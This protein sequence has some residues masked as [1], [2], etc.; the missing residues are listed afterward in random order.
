MLPTDYEEQ[1][2]E[3]M[4]HDSRKLAPPYVVHGSQTFHG[5]RDE[6]CPWEPVFENWHKGYIITN[7]DS[8]EEGRV[9]EINHQCVS[10]PVSPLSSPKPKQIESRKRRSPEADVFEQAMKK[11]SLGSSF[12]HPIVLD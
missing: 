11:I 6:I 2:E 9:P 4:E 10:E 5:K 1:M 3:T 8:F 12:E 7:L